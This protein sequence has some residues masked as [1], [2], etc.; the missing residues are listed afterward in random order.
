MIRKIFFLPLA[1]A[2]LVAAAFATDLPSAWRSW[3]YSRS[4]ESPRSGVLN[5]V[6]L[7]RE[8]F[9]HSENHL[10]DIR[11]VDDLGNEQPFELR[12]QPAP[13][14][15][16]VNIPATLR[17]NSFVPGQ[18]T[19]L[20]V[21]V[22]AHA[23]FHGSLRVQT[24]ESDFIN[25]VEVAASDDAHLWRIVKPRTPI[26]RFRRENLEGSQT[27]R[28]SENNARY[29]R[30]RI[31]EPSHQFPVSS[32]DVFAAQGTIAEVPAAAV[33]LVA[34]LPPESASVPSQTQ[35]TVDLGSAA[36]PVAE[37]NFETTQPE[38]YRAVRILTSNDAKEWQPA[39]DGEI[40]RYKVNGKAGESLHVRCYEIWGARYWR[41]EILNGN[42]APLAAVQMS[43][44]MNQRFALF[45]PKENRI[46]RLIYGNA[47][48]AAPQY[49]LARSLHIQ[50]NEVMLHLNL[51][52]EEATTNYADP[53]PYT[54]RHPNL[55]WLALGL[56]IALLGYAALR[57][58]RTSGPAPQ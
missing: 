4:I 40:Y 9:A 56:A 14:S 50:P 13:P 17:E 16:S 30:L 22:G 51:G 21:D 32:I 7:D 1:F 57:A 36:V 3:L 29:L 8:A 55:L 41:S 31:Q 26:S 24:P 44:V 6:T 5:C 37:L 38:F 33:P 47:R 52:P 20:V 42:D 12:N 48:A 53:R 27:I 46:Y 25:W 19:Q 10:A 11:I 45:H 2:T 23:S 35:W 34:M 18:F 49:D 15:Q 54:E 58:L 43:L 28:Y 39:G